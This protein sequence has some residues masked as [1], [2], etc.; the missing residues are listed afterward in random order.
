MPD[1]NRV[2]PQKLSVAELIARLQLMPQASIVWMSVPPP[3]D[4]FS[5][6]IDVKDAGNGEVVLHGD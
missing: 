6:V 1:D 5:A 3:G 2:E 4:R